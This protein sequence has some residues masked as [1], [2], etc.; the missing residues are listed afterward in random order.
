MLEREGVEAVRMLGV[1]PALCAHSSHE[2]DEQKPAPSDS[3]RS[4]LPCRG[5]P[6]FLLIISP[7]VHRACEGGGEIG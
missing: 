2:G 6:P 7:T 3:R 4:V 1:L 5:N